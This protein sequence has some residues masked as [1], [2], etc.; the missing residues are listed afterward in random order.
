MSL[1][2]LFP[3]PK[4]TGRGDSMVCRCSC[5]SISEIYKN[6]L[7]GAKREDLTEA[8]LAQGNYKIAKGE[9]INCD[10]D[11]ARVR[12][13]NWYAVASRRNPGFSRRVDK[14]KNKPKNAE[15]AAYYAVA[16]DTLSPGFLTFQP[17]AYEII[18]GGGVLSKEELAAAN[19]ICLVHQRLTALPL[20]PL[21][22]LSLASLASAVN[23]LPRIPA[24]PAQTL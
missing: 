24:T 16:P 15:Q 17:G 8:Q 19:A 7:R 6:Y 3:A 5:G 20:G 4:R 22:E 9:C 18:T 10:D 13:K 2:P 11:A 23:H 12:A 1:T 14:A 21:F